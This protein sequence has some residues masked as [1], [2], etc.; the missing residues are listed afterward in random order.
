MNRKCRIKG[1]SQWTN[2]EV[3]AYTSRRILFLY[4][5]I[6]PYLIVDIRPKSI[7]WNDDSYKRFF[8]NYELRNRAKYDVRE[9]M[10]THMSN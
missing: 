10:P 2:I 7:E 6:T 3:Y 5:K 4:M 1:F 8:F 9:I